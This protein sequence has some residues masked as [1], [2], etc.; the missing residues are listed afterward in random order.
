MV[1]NDHFIISTKVYFNK[2]SMQTLACLEGRCALV[3]SDSI[4]DELGYLK[5]AQDYLKQ[6]GI[7]S[8]AFT[9]VKPDPDISVVASGVELYE[10]CNADVLVALGGGSC[11]DTAKAILYF[12]WQR[13]KAMGEKFTKPCFVA[14]PTTSGTGSEVTNF[15]VISA[16]GTKNV[17]IDELIGPDVALLDSICIQ[18]VPKSVIADTGLDVLTHALEAYVSTDATDFTDALAEKTAELIFGHLKKLYD[19]PRNDDARDRVQNAS[20]MAGIAFT[21]S[22]LGITHSLAHALGAEFHL[23][24]GR[25]NALLM[26]AVIA[27][28]ADIAGTA[29]NYA[30]WK[31]QK[32]AAE[33]NL[34]AR[35]PREGTVSLLR[36][37]A[38]LKR[39]LGVP[40]SIEAT[41]RVEADKFE[42]A[43]TKM[44]ED[45]M[46]DR[47]TPTNPVVPTKA[48]LI[49]LYRK[50][51]K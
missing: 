34:P 37:I 49:A 1:K 46:N 47:C 51:F 42:A 15:S 3:V 24:H 27:Y 20:C 35:T 13:R 38:Q 7:E 22:N 41:G 32:M 4:M 40:Q 6:A 36:A 50:C 2:G 30:A 18:H 29:N 14:I 45:A 25:A 31:Y 21:N 16:N 23:P 17:L 19:D 12:V 44:A 43:L 26:E 33:L 11:I 5:K 10:K 8:V 28:N 48:D 39:E 9:G